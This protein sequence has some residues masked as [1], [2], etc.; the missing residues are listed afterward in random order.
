MALIKSQI[1]I[2]IVLLLFF[3]TTAQSAGRVGKVAQKYKGISYRY[4]GLSSRGVDCSGLVLKALRKFDIRVPHKASQIY[5][6]G[7]KV[8]KKDL[9]PDDLVFFSNNRHRIS[10]IGIYL[11]DGLFI[12]ASS[13]K[14]KVITSKLSDY[15][16]HYVG[17]KRLYNATPE[18]KKK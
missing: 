9:Q 2:F 8:Q 16:R 1:Y 14:G 10:H 12:H 3:T 13:G 4:G 6:L 7:T 17:A 5:K 15:R 11:G 18:P